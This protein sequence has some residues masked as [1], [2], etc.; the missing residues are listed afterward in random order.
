M[1]NLDQRDKV[2][3]IDTSP[4]PTS[5]SQSYAS[6][7]KIGHS[8]SKSKVETTIKTAEKPKNPDNKPEDRFFLR[9][10]QDSSLRPYSGY[11]L[12]N[13]IK[14]RLESEKNCFPR[15]YSQ[16]QDLLFALV[17]EIHTLKK[18]TTS[19]ICGNSVTEKV[20]PWKSYQISIIPRSF[21]TINGDFQHCLG[22]V[23]PD[24][25]CYEETLVTSVLT[26]KCKVYLS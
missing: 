7:A 11:A 9:L 1:S 22:P 21:S 3:S 24:S 23:T 12:Q 8:N 2:G 20:T 6:T 16:K 10:P 4:R 18:I 19:N 26:F 25:I 15:F 13:Y 14:S 5:L 17:K